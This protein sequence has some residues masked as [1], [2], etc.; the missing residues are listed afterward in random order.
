M[1]RVLSY[2]IAKEDAGTEG[3]LIPTRRTSVL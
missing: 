3:I 1:E 2:S